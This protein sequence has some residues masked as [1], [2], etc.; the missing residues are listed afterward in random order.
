MLEDLGTASTGVDALG[1]LYWGDNVVWELDEQGS[2]EPFFR[3]IASLAPA[4]RYAGYVSLTRSP[5][6]VVRDFPGLEVIDARPGT[7]LAQPG[8]LLN[9]IRTRCLDTERDLLLFDPLEA[10][11]GHWG[12]ET[13]QR[14]FIRSCPLLLELGAIAYWSLVPGEYPLGLRRE[15][16]EVTQCVIAVADGRVRI[17][18]AEGRPFGVQG[19]VFRCHLENGTPSLEPAPAVRAWAELCAPSVCSAISRRASSHV[20]PASLRARSPRRSA[21]GEACPSRRSST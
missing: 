19:S 4:Y 5:D 18:K 9:E 14:F 13:A 1:G 15:I 6:E 16:E 7:S 2:V 10:M 3:A 21:G 17:A 11:A 8:P 20:S 12:V